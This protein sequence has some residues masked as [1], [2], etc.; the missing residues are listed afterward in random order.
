WSVVRMQSLGL[1]V[2][3][4]V[5]VTT[6]ACRAY[7]EAGHFPD[8][9]DAELDAAVAWLEQAT[10]RTLG[11]SDKPLLVSV[12]SG[13]A[14]S[15]PGMMDTVLNLGIDAT[16]EAALAAES[17]DARFARDTHRRFLEL[18]AAIVLKATLDASDDPQAILGAIEAQGLSVPATPREQLRAAVEA[19]FASWNSRRAKRYRK[20]HDIPDTLGTAV[21]VQAMV[22]GNLDDASG[23]GVLFSRNPLTGDPAPYGEYLHRAQGEDVVSG[24]FTPEPLSAL[25]QAHPELHAELM[26]AAAKL[27][28]ENGDVQDIEFTVQQGKLFLLQSRSAK[29]A[30]QAAV[31]FAVDMVEEGRIDADTAIAR[32]SA[33]QVRS[34]LKPRLVDGATDDAPVLARG[35]VACQGVGV[36]VVVT[37]SDEAER[38][39]AAGEAVVLA[40]ATTSPEDVHGMIAAVAVVTEQ[41][42]STSHAAVVGR[43]LGV[44]CLVGCGDASVTTLAGQTVTVDANAGVV[45][46]GALAVETPREEDDPRL[47]RLT[48]WAT[49]RAPLAVLDENAAE[50]AGAHD[51]DHVDGAEDPERLPA[52]LTGHAC[53]RGGAIESDAGVAAALA[54]GVGTIVARHPL[55]VL[56]AA[57]QARAGT[58]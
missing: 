56:L 11:G 2:P 43:A 26:A 53:V 30:P 1:P 37:D 7:L 39:H 38:R 27:E 24:R 52:L 54:A 47:A 22:F 28:A 44:P 15:M 9:L 4:A 20:H 58:A 51:L 29:R 3:P 55:P 10:G 14:I 25:E 5:V 21:T 6:D 33:E 36:G 12:R 35:E 13:A 16:T 17:G 42:G 32:V 18:Y 45:Y 46:A 23:T 19:V 34:L 31:R 41:G 57:I 8:G 48:A 49:E 40:R 50:A